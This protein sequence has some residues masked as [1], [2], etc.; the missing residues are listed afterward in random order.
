MGT[1][2]LMIALLCSIAFNG[3]AQKADYIRPGLLRSSLTISPSWMLNKSEVNYNVT[4]F[5]EGYLSKH[6]SVRG[7]THYFIDGKDDVPFYKFNSQWYIGV[8]MHASKN[9]VDGH[10]GF[11]PGY[12]FSQV[13][14]DL[15]EDGKH[16]LHFTPTFSLNVGG[17]YY[18]WKVFNIFVNATYVHSSVRELD[19]TAGFDGRAD[20]LIL[21][22]GLGFHINT[23]RAK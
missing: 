17:T 3:A 20:E 2:K 15:K 23:V 10:I 13:N 5:L 7:E 12:S 22:A 1:S 4:G 21:S 11:M 19:R 9:N 6:L 18:F 16:Q 8:L 14:G